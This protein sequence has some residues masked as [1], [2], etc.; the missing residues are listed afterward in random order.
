MNTFKTKIYIANVDCLED[1]AL[2]D[3][4]YALVNEY[5]REKTDRMKFD[6]DKRLSLGVE[7]LLKRALEEI[8]V[9]YESINLDYGKNGKPYIKGN[10][11]YFNLSHSGNMAVCAVSKNEIGVDIEEVERADFKIS[12]RIFTESEISHINNSDDEYIRLW[13]LKESYMKYCGSGLSIA[14]KDIEIEFYDNIPHYKDLDFF[15]YEIEGYR[16][17]LCG[18]SKAEIEIVNLAE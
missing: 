3:A 8:G 10:D 18:D 9:D 1:G 15:E 14:P 5:R 16:L 12:K 2:F 6:K 11:I 4:L 7:L 13:T 17:A